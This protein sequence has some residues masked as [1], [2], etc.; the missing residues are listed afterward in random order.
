[1]TLKDEVRI[2]HIKLDF[3]VESQLLISHYIAATTKNNRSHEWEKVNEKMKKAIKKHDER[4]DE[5]Y[6]NSDSATNIED[7]IS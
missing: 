6:K 3:L 5:Y 7:N 2:M 1:M 4:I